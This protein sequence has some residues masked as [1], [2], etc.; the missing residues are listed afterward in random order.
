MAHMPAL[1]AGGP[2][3]AVAPQTVPQVPQLLMS[4]GTHPVGPLAGQARN[5]V[6]HVNPQT[7]GVP[8]Q[9]S[10]PFV[11][12]AGHTL[13]QVPQLATSA[14]RL[15]QMPG[16]VPHKV[17]GATHTA[18][19]M[20]AI[21]LVPA[22]H[23]WPHVPQL[24]V[25]LVVSTHAVPQSVVFG[26]AA[27][28]HDMPQFMPS[29]V[30][31]PPPVGIA[32][33]V[34]DTVPQEPVE[35]LLQTPPLQV[36]VPPEG[37]AGHGLA[38]PPQLARLLVVSTH[39]PLQFVCA[40]GPAGQAVMQVPLGHVTVPPVGAVQFVHEAP[41][42]A[43]EMVTHA[44][45]HKC[46]PPGHMPAPQTPALHTAEPPDG[47]L[48]TMLQP[49]QLLMSLVVS[50]HAPPHSVVFGGVAPAQDM[51]HMVPSHVAE[52]PPD[53][54][55]QEVHAVVPHELVDEL[56]T[57]ALPHRCWPVGHVLPQT[58]A[59]HV[60]VPPVGG[61][62]QTMPQAPQLVR[63]LVVS[64]HTP[65]QFVCPEGQAWTHEPLGH[66]TVPPVGAAQFVHDAPH[67]LAEMVTHA[68]PHKC[69]PV[70]HVPVPQTPALHVAVPP[71]GAVHPLPQ[72]P[73][74]LMSFVS[75]THT[76]LHT[77][78]PDAQ[79]MEGPAAGAV[80]VVPVPHLLP[81]LPQLLGSLARLE[82]EPLHT[83]GA[84]AAQHTEAPVAPA[85]QVE[86]AAHL[87]PHAPQLLG[88]VTRLTQTPPQLVC[89]AGQVG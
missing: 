61:A 22:A 60:S 35:E 10:V 6:L 62:G 58:L 64:M 43:A 56:L 53:G 14:D 7:P 12:G 67:E 34:H 30:A 29:H 59:L 54:T 87:V 38:Q 63:L 73:Q 89:P 75:L 69:W 79:H 82:H 49:P 70:G 23:A 72:P 85:V 88:S 55:G 80:Q 52:P 18:S 86:P 27:V 3:S 19:H 46:W 4:F 17:A 50:T 83:V 1:H 28:A 45:P 39:T 25:L 21:Q 84:E 41:H 11:G 81:Q 57:Q 77:L 42:E 37:A 65:L 47:G 78:C 51:P 20:P 40:G 13:P 2:P 26:G 71:I 33:P 5:P 9:I 15:V 32:H 76:P 36:S 44:L 48:H 16:A 8:L 68:P 31:E 24:L 74:L 66:V